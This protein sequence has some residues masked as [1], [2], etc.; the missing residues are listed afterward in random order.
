MRKRNNGEKCFSLSENSRSAQQ[1]EAGCRKTDGVAEVAAAKTERVYVNLLLLAGDQIENKIINIGVT[2]LA[3][4]LVGRSCQA[5]KA[6]IAGAAAGN[7]FVFF[8]NNAAV[9]HRE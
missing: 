7:A 8:R 9:L 1:F 5:V 3:Y 6:W 2:L 4:Q